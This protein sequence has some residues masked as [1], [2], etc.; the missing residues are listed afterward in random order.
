MTDTRFQEIETTKFEYESGAIR[1]RRRNKVNIF[2]GI[3]LAVWLCVWTVGGFSAARTLPGA[4]MN[5]ETLFIIFWLCAWV[6]GEAYAV[7]ML[8]WLFLG[9]EVIEASP[10]AL[11]HKLQI[12]SFKREKHYKPGGVSNLRFRDGSYFPAFVAARGT[13]PSALIF[14]YGNKSIDVLRGISEVEALKVISEF[15]PKMGVGKVQNG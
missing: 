3:F 5:P 2:I 13:K 7:M 6:L 10:L 11:T 14:D 9:S 8:L 1:Y 15:G 4:D 12:G